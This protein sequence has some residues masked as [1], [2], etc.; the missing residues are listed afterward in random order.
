MTAPECTLTAQLIEVNSLHPEIIELLLSC[1]EGFTWNAGDYLWL[2]NAKGIAKPFSIA[3]LPSE[4]RIRLQIAHVES[5]C[6]WLDDLL[7]ETQVKISVAG[8]QF[9]WPQGNA[10]L[11]LFAGGTGITPIM[12]LLKTHLAHSHRR[13]MLYWGVRNLSLAY[14]KLALDT[15]AEKHPHFA[16]QLVL[17]A[18]ASPQGNKCLHGLI[19]D[20]LQQNQIILPQEA[21][22]LMICGPWPMVTS[23][24]SVIAERKIHSLQ[25]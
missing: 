21:S 7:D 25:H 16:Y 17:S 15:L 8:S 20:L 5:I 11:V 23:I 18:D 1:P 12:T 9:R 14:L 6:D 13:V 10:P 2:E 24:K 3:S 4:N 22:D 19:P